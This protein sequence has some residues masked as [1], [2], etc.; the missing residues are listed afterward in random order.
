MSDPTVATEPPVLTRAHARTDARATVVAST[1]KVTRGRRA[2]GFTVAR[3]EALWTRETFS[4]VNQHIK[5]RTLVLWNTVMY[6]M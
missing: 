4:T 6:Q 3:E 5:A 1:V 2:V